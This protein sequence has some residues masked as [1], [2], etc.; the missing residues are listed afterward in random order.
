MNRK[1][2]IFNKSSTDNFNEG[3]HAVPVDTFR[4]ASPVSDTQL[5]LFFL[6]FVGSGVNS[7]ASAKICVAMALL[8]KL[9]MP[10]SGSHTDI[11]L[12]VSP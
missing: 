3:H 1:Y 4:G 2:A 6:P 7:G 12:K 9:C 10:F 5:A 11:A 8:K